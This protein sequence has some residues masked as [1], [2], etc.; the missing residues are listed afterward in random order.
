MTGYRS[1]PEFDDFGPW[2]DEVRTVADLPRLYRQAG[3]EPAAYRLVLKV[4]RDIERREAHP[5]MHLY[6]HL[7]AVDAETFTVLSR[8]DDTYDTRRIP[9]DQ[10]V[11]IQDSVRM[12]DGRL[13]VRTVG[14]G[15]LTVPYNGSSKAPIRELIRVLRRSYLPAGPPPDDLAAPVMPYMGRADTALLTEYQRLVAEEPGLR[16]TLVGERQLL[17]PVTPLDRM[18][19]RLRPVTLHASILVTDDREIQVLHRS[20]WITT[21]AGDWSLARTV[22]PRNRITDITVRPHE[23]YH[24]VHVLA[25]ESGAT[26][27]EFPVTASRHADAAL[28]RGFL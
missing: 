11:A 18:R 13:T 9:L 16:L 1:T 24:Y 15:E 27:L 17:T 28:A 22:L 3:I 20:H 23:R 8:R 25:V 6:D 7:L 21:T 12:L 26:R 2:I 19:S 10:V 4:P 14:G 5:G